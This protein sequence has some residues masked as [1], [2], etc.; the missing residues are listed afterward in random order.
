MALVRAVATVR[1][2]VRRL[3]SAAAATARGSVLAAD[4][5]DAVDGAVELKGIMQK[6]SVMRI[7]KI[8][9]SDVRHTM[10]LNVRSQDCS[11]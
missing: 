7:R 8:L 6:A 9:E 2:R 5:G 11:D 10:E 4:L 1:A 3:S